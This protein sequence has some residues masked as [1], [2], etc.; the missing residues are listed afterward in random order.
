VNDWIIEQRMNSPVAEGELEVH[1][2]R[3]LCNFNG[4]SARRLPPPTSFELGVSASRA[5]KIIDTG[6]DKNP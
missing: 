4:S 1:L 2:A 3:C 5:A 6:I